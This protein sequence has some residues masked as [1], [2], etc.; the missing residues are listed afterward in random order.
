VRDVPTERKGLENLLRAESPA[1][2][3]YDVRYVEPRFRVGV[4]ATL[5]YDAVVARIPQGVR[6][7]DAA[8]RQGAVLTAAPRTRN[9]PSMVVG[10]SARVGTS[11]KVT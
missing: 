5:G 6:L 8:L 10:T 2:T 4:Q 7:G 9:G 3:V 11:T 1:H